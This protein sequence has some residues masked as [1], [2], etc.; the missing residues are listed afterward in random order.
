MIYFVPGPPVFDS[1]LLLRTDV[2]AGLTLTFSFRLRQAGSLHR[3]SGDHFFDV[4]VSIKGVSWNHADEANQ[5]C[6]VDDD[7]ERIIE[8][9]EYAGGFSRNQQR[10]RSLHLLQL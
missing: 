2:G 6:L 3:H 1:C 9:G 7:A 4:S 10:G 8:G 5:A